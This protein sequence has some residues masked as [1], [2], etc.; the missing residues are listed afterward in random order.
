MV[1]RSIFLTISTDNFGITLIEQLKKSY[2][3]CRHQSRDTVRKEGISNNNLLLKINDIDHEKRKIV[4]DFIHCLVTLHADVRK[5][6]DIVL[7]N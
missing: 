5:K 3:R 4:Q 6:K 1:D 2:D 7:I